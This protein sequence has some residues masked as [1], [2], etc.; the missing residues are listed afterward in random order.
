M[1]I[2]VVVYLEEGEGKKKVMNP[3]MESQEGKGRCLLAGWLF[4]TRN[5]ETQVLCDR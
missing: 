2:A 4:R 3:V 5:E 1:A